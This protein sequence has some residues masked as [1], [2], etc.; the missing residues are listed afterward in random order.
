MRLI[1][2][3]IAQ[4][5]VFDIA[6][7][8]DA[9]DPELANRIVDRLRRAPM[10]LLAHPELGPR[11][12]ER[13]EARKWHVPGTPFLLLYVVADDRINVQRVVHAAS[14]WRP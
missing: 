6:D 9:I 3:R 13:S 7:H 2:S 14:D 11:I 1:W 12:D 4:N 10:P 8:Y 5:D